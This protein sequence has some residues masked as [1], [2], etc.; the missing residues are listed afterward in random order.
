MVCI[1]MHW[2]VS[3]CFYWQINF[4]IIGSKKHV[5]ASGRVVNALSGST[6]GFTCYA[7]RSEPPVSI[8]ISVYSSVPYESASLGSHAHTGYNDVLDDAKMGWAR[9][10]HS[11]RVFVLNSGLFYI[12]PTLA[13]SDLLQRIAYRLETE[14]GWD[15]A[16]F[17]EVCTCRQHYQNCMT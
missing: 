12:R 15:Q 13:A 7:L 6:C 1:S 3:H 8:G 2:H 14:D 9:F 10:A 5:V 17:N 11:M 16:I 4:N